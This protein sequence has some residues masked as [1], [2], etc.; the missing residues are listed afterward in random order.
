MK[1]C[2]ALSILVIL[3]AGCARVPFSE[4]AATLMVSRDPVAVVERFHST[5]PE[6]FQLLN[7]V[8]FEYNGRKFLGIG[9]LDINTESR[10]FHVACLNPMGVKLFELSG[11]DRGVSTPYMLEALAQYGD[12]GAAV[13]NDIRRMY[14]NLIPPREASVWKRKNQFAYWQSEGSGTLEY[15]FA[16]ANADLVQKRYYEDHVIA[17][18]VSY[19]EYQEHMGKRY[20]HGIVLINY[21]Y[22]YRLTVR[23]KEIYG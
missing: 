12:I 4:T 20:P 1:R 5:A 17:W 16:G 8:V 22:G 3:T 19:Y 11:D 7:S 9:N 21:Q 14:F 6:Y 15:V 2:I 18:Q 10:T 23:L 13:G